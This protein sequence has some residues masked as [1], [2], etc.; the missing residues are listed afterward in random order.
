MKVLAINGSARKDG[1]TAILV[2]AVFEEL[3]NEGIETR[4]EQLHGL[5]LSGCVACY[6]CFKRKDKRCAV[7]KDALNGLIEAMLEADGV[8]LA[9]PTYFADVTAGL[10]AVIERAGMVARANGDMFARKTGAAVVSQRRG[11]GMQTFNSLNAFFFIS[12][13]VVPGSSYWNF[14]FGRD[15][16]QVEGDQEG[17]KTMRDL[18]RN[19]AWLMKKL[20]C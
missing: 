12:Q 13:M 18:G 14:G 20:A 6:E 15:I 17:M 2:R 5:K 1:N 4:M 10:R 3:E 11:G 9:S 8:I 7:T 16:G 19:M